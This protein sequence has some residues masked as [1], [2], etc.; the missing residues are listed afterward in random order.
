MATDMMAQ[1]AWVINNLGTEAVVT[2]PL[3][4][5]APPALV[6]PIQITA[7]SATVYSVLG[8]D[9][10]RLVVR[11]R[12]SFA[13]GFNPAI[14]NVMQYNS[15]V[16]PALTNTTTFNMAIGAW[17]SVSVPIV[18]KYLQITAESP[19]GSLVDAVGYFYPGG[20]G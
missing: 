20:V 16:V 2:V 5:A 13:T 11:N 14:V 6:F 9:E 18:E 3:V 7:T 12:G 4:A 17:L 8:I 15:A 19:L 10:L 1:N